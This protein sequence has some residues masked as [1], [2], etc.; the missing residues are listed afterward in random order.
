MKLTQA[1]RKFFDDIAGPSA[2]MAAGSMG[3]GAV[4]SLLLAGA[5]FQY[6]L[7]WVVVLMAPFFV[8][9]VNTAS[10]IGALNPDKGLMTLISQN[11][12][13]GV[14]W[15]ILLIN[16]PIHVL[17]IMGQVSVMASSAMSFFGIAYSPGNSGL[18]VELGFSL[19]IGLGVIWLVLF[20]GY[21]RM[22]SIMTGLMLVMLLCFLSIAVR[23]F[24]DIVP[25]MSGFAPSFPDDLPVPDE[26]TTRRSLTSM[27][28]IVGSA[29]APAALLGMPYLSAD[30]G[31]GSD[32]LARDLQRTTINLG[33]VF[34]AYSIFVI[35]AG[36]FA[37]YSLPNNGSID[38]VSEAGEVLSTVFPGVLA[39]LGPKLFSLGL[40]FAALTTLI[41]AAQVTSYILLDGIGR[42]WRFTAQN[43]TFLVVLSA[44]ILGPAAAAP[45]WDFPALLKMILLMG[46]N[47]VVIPAVLIV[48]IFLSNKQAVVG[49]YKAGRVRNMMMLALLAAAL[50]VAWVKAPGY[51]AGLF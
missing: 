7:I 10:R 49:A 28:A 1:V 39:P 2:V 30:S 13:P 40:F 16:I 17:I 38:T 4:T 25:I 11:L 24:Q 34:S 23:G 18:V 21:D 47:L 29:I 19:A 22:Q 46:A 3:A 32:S 9:A 5:W 45:F 44:F 6:S 20:R 12:H 36:G 14:V 33:V 35:I 27:M 15:I 37:L 42:S 51:F 43:R 48:V 41:V 50:C 26:N 31:A 8:V